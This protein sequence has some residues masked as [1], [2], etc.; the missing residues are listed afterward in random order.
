MKFR[1]K[2]VEVEATQW[3]KNGDHPED[4]LSLSEGLKPGEFRIYTFEKMPEGEVV[5]YFRHPGVDGQSLCR[6]GKPY[7]THGWIDDE[8]NGKSVCPGDW[9]VTDSEGRYHRYSPKTFALNYEAV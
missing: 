8:F 9:I 4:Y 1:K 2:P 5:R 7:D 6:C 3:F